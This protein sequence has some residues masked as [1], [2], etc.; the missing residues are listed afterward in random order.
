MLVGGKDA[1][2]NNTNGLLSFFNQVPSRRSIHH[3]QETRFDSNSCV[4]FALL[5]RYLLM[6]MCVLCGVWAR[7]RVQRQQLLLPGII[8]AI[9]YTPTDPPT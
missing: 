7:P 3:S 9:G 6:W 8:T 5:L 4:S 1:F 2:H